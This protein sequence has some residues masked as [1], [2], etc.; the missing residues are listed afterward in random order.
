M[1]AT[2]LRL[3]KEQIMKPTYSSW[4]L[5]VAAHNILVDN[6]KV[7]DSQSYW[8]PR[9]AFGGSGAA[10]RAEQPWRNAGGPADGR[11]CKAQSGRADAE[12]SYYI[13]RCVAESRA[14][15][16]AERADGGLRLLLE[17]CGRVRSC[18][19]GLFGNVVESRPCGA[20]GRGGAAAGRVPLGPVIHLRPGGF[21]GRGGGPNGDK[22]PWGSLSGGHLKFAAALP[23][24]L[25]RC[26]PEYLGVP[27]WGPLIEDMRRYPVEG[28]EGCDRGGPR[29][30]NERR[31]SGWI[32]W[33]EWA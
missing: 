9:A 26:R 1:L 31:L 28:G 32:M 30:V 2:K 13:R 19:W 7:P 20:L 12:A 4:H 15:Q 33:A 25:G 10:V 6:E 21:N 3:K 18:A 11:A 29:R 8:S 5:M 23:W 14:V 22:L 17:V 24:L 16:D 27:L